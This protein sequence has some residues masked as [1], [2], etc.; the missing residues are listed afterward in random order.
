[1]VVAEAQRT[2]VKS[3]PEL[4]SELSDPAALAR[5][6]GDLGEVRIVRTDPEQSVEW[7]A[8]DTRGRVEITP[9]GWGTKV[10]LSVTIDTP[11]AP[12]DPAGA[13]TA[14]AANVPAERALADAAAPADAEPADAEPADAEPADARPSTHRSA[15]A[16]SAMPDPVNSEPTASKPAPPAPA[17]PR[18]AASELAAP[19][20][21]TAQAEG[22]VRRFLARLRHAF[23]GG[24]GGAGRSPSNGV[25][26]DPLSSI[27]GGRGALAPAS[28]AAK[29][30]ANAAGAHRS[31][32][33]SHTERRS[34]LSAQ[35]P[36]AAVRSREDR[37][38]RAN[39][40]AGVGSLASRATDVPSSNGD[41]APPSHARSEPAEPPAP[42]RA[43]EEPTDTVAASRARGDVGSEGASEDR[44]EEQAA[45]TTEVLSTMLDRLG[46][47]HHRPFSRS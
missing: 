20:L 24:A 9:A 1:M 27:E 34:V 46:E 44:A 28:V 42:S 14:S 15:T 30:K 2:L 29:S 47:A 7:E 40:D 12:P 13:K 26:T 43:R 33:A 39:G 25:A 23:R 10:T 17:A 32:D 38:S 36:I 3:P 5:H 18:P 35:S 11:H 41:G 6:L 37:A 45:R 4:W 19:E 22:A 8:D 21:K 16:S 31:A